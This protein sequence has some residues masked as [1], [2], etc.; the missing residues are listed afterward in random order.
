MF[1]EVEGPSSIAAPSMIRVLGLE[2][3]F[4]VRLMTMMPLL[5]PL[6]K[7]T[8]LLEKRDSQKKCASAVKEVT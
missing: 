5:V 7:T 1:V 3:I 2:G 4:S 6:V 8:S